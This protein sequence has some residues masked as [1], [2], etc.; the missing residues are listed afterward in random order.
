[1]S[2]NKTK[3]IKK[4]TIFKIIIFSSILIYFILRAVPNISSAS[5][6]TLLPERQVVGEEYRT[7]AIVLRN[8]ELY[9]SA[10][11][12]SLK[13]SVKE[14]ERVPA[15]KHI[16]K[17]SLSEKSSTHSQKLEE[18]N[19]KIKVLEEAKK[20]IESE[21]DKTKTES[22]INSIIKEIQESL[23]NSEY[24]KAEVLREKLSIYESLK[25]DLTGGK[26][27]IDESLN[28]LKAE[29]DKVA[30]EINESTINY[31]AKNAGVVSF[32]IDGYEETYKFSD[33]SKYKFAD[34]EEK[35][36][37][38]SLKDNKSH[39]N[40]Q[41]IFKIINNYEWYML[42][43][44]SNIKDVDDLRK[45]NNI[46][47]ALKD[48]EIVGTVEHK[49]KSKDNISLLCR[50]NTNF[51]DFYDKRF[52][53]IDVI[54][55][56]YDG[57]KIPSRSIVEKDNQK[58]VYVKDISGIIKFRPIDIMYEKEDNVYVNIGDEQGNILIGIDE[59]PVK[60]VTKFDE[61]ILNTGSVKE[62]M[63]LK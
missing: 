63:I 14:G 9:K 8:E 54:R 31:Y 42:I 1:M 49:Q 44:G 57:F 19:K 22:N 62:G 26:A 52:V 20:D 12:G 3:T 41:P 6:K 56:K 33:R 40:N 51:E 59:E 43:D 34:L 47:I 32:K 7:R 15:G 29:K 39:D 17:L 2:N 18:L 30:K 45:G 11:K 53:D 23:R 35:N 36:I 5:A 46:R 58:G 28:K 60:T 10:G 16:A 24:E 4:N 37:K 48:K 25:G 61:I 13:Y 21:K 50:F 27:L 38:N 55:Y